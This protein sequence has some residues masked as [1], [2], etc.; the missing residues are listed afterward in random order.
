M[1]FNADEERC[2]LESALYCVKMTLEFRQTMSYLSTVPCSCQI[3]FYQL[4]TKRED[5]ISKVV[6]FVHVLIIS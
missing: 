5:D 2:T 6:H 1:S 4:F 3:A